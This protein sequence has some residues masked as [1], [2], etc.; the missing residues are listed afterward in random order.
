MHARIFYR[1]LFIADFHKLIYILGPSTWWPGQ[2]TFQAKDI[3]WTV[4]VGSQNTVF[5][6]HSEEDFLW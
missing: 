6:E 5:P 4:D 3:N 1:K 2:K